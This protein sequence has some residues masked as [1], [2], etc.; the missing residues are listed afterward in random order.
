[1]RAISMTFLAALIISAPSPTSFTGRQ[2][3]LSQSERCFLSMW[4]YVTA[5]QL[6]TRRPFCAA[7][8]SGLLNTISGSPQ[9]GFVLTIL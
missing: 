6:S 4:R 1:M 2:R 7:I 9:V 5:K 8:D 3:K